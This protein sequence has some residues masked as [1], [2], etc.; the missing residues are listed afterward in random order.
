MSGFAESGLPRRPTSA[1]PAP[2]TP[3]P[4]KPILFPHIPRTAGFTLKGILQATF[5]MERS[6]LDVHF[7]RGPPRDMTGFAVV[8]GHRLARFFERSFGTRWLANGVTLLRDPVNRVV[9]QARHI[10]AMPRNVHHRELVRDVREPVE[11]F[12]RLPHL[13]NFQTKMLASRLPTATLD[14]A[15]LTAAKA[16]LERMAFGL[17][18]RFDDSV[19]LFAERFGLVLP[20]FGTTNASPPTGD[21]DLRGARFRDEARRWNEL[22]CELYQYA[23]ELF[24]ARVSLYTDRLFDLASESGEMQGVLRISHRLVE[25]TV[26]LPADVTSVELHGWLLIDGHAPDAVVA[27]SGSSATLVVGRIVNPQAARDTFNADNR[28]AGVAGTI[29]TPPT[30]NSVTVI[31]FDRVRCVRAERTIQFHRARDEEAPHRL[32]AMGSG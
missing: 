19:T 14:S 31:A 4:S 30:V 6:L 11:I 12:E 8:E 13:A 3:D 26:D 9:S 10:R 23:T 15:A 2:G 27:L 25:G 20:E 22:D 18:E 28:Y 1:D 17:T 5:G 32:R 29:P 24:A 21:D 7:D 16:T